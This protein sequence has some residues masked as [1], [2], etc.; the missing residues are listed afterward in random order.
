MFERFSHEA[1]EVIVMA[2][3]QAGDLGHNWIGTEHLLLGLAAQREGGAAA[4]L[5]E[6]GLD[7]AS[8]REAVVGT[9][10]RGTPV[11]GPG[12]MD[13]ADEAALRALGI[14]MDTVRTRAEEMFGRGALDRPVPSRSRR[15]RWVGPRRRCRGPS[16]HG[17]QRPFAARA[18]KSLELALREALRLHHGWIG[19]EHV[20]LGI[21]RVPE[22]LAAQILMDRGVRLDD[23]R[24]RVLARLGQ[25]A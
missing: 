6:V 13:D 11:A 1:R 17:T 21:L 2:Q 20:L 7:L 4:A 8:L 3:E 15:R 14:D 9:L 18:K 10:G 24:S 16:T 19:P 22:S 5:V 25:V 23:L 12:L